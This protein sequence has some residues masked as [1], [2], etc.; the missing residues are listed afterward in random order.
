[1]MTGLHR[2]QP[3]LLTTVTTIVG[4]LPLAS[5]QSIDLI[6]RTWTAGG[7][8]PSMW[9]PFAQAI[10][11]GLGFATLLTLVA[12]PLRLILPQ[13]LREARAQLSEHMRGRSFSLRMPSL[14]RRRRIG[15]PG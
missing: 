9:A 8:L 15:R 1:M 13:R 5:Y 11:F 14:P 2:L 12:T 3:V 6:N 10:I 7:Q 4:L